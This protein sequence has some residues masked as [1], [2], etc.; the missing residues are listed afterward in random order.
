MSW[1]CF[2][3]KKA[4][5]HEAQIGAAFGWFGATVV[6]SGEP[7]FATGLLLSGSGVERWTSFRLFMEGGLRGKGGALAKCKQYMVVGL[8]LG[9]QREIGQSGGRMRGQGQF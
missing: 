6:M 7:D 2:A 8:A 9:N 5:W 3:P 4:L 1:P